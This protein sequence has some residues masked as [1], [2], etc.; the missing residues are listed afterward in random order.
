MKKILFFLGVIVSTATT[1]QSNVEKEIVGTWSIVEIV[2]LAV[3]P[4]AL[5]ASKVEQL[6]QGLRDM[7]FEFGDDH[8][9]RVH[10]TESDLNID[11]GYWVAKG[12]RIAVGPWDAQGS[13]LGSMTLD[14]QQRE[15]RWFFVVADVAELEVRKD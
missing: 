14:V 3:P 13:S 15:G 8:H 5:D 7:T 1:A 9:L 12:N 10:T 4:G 11:D 2:R 6:R